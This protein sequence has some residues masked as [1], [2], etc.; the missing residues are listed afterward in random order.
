MIFHVF[1]KTQHFPVLYHNCSAWTPGKSFAHAA[2]SSISI[3]AACWNGFL[4]NLEMT[5][6][7]GPVAEISKHLV[8]HAPK[9]SVPRKP[10]HMS[11]FLYSSTRKTLAGRAYATSKTFRSG[12]V[13]LR[14]SNRDWCTAIFCSALFKAVVAISWI[15]WATSQL[16]LLST[17]LLTPPLP[18]R[19]L[20][21][22][23]QQSPGSKRIRKTT[24]ETTKGR[25]SRDHLQNDQT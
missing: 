11:P 4:E 18:R 25:E 9:Q 19:P 3:H 21:L 23:V 7:V 1:W 17:R 10:F 2:V 8:A 5:N 6:V 24:L 16:D 12:L 13:G 14:Q 22:H 20:Q 15:F